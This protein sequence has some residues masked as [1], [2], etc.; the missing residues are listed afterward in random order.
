MRIMRLDSRLCF[1]DFSSG[2]RSPWCDDDDD[3]T[4]S[5]TETV[6]TCETNMG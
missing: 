6:S 3:D 2:Y 4:V 5:A 1:L